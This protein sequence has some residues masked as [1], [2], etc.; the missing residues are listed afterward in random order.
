MT[1]GRH[2]EAYH[3]L[4]EEIRGIEAQSRQHLSLSQE[5]SPRVM[6]DKKDEG[7]SD[8]PH[9]RDSS[10]KSLKLAFII[11]LQVGFSTG[12]VSKVVYRYSPTLRRTIIRGYAERSQYD[13]WQMDT[14]RLRVPRGRIQRTEPIG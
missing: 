7:P 1:L 14:E 6:E 10:H 2:R 12:H 9:T 5:P 13:I 3:Q 8:Y 4:Q 11:G